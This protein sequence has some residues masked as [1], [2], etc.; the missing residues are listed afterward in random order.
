MADYSSRLTKRI[1]S[2]GDVLVD[3][4]DDCSFTAVGTMSFTDGSNETKTLSDLVGSGPAAPVAPSEHWAFSPGGY[5]NAISTVYKS[6]KW[7][8]DGGLSDAARLY[9]PDPTLTA[10]VT[11]MMFALDADGAG[12]TAVEF[13]IKRN[14]VTLETKAFSV[15]QEINQLLTF[16]NTHE[17]ESGDYLDLEIRRTNG[18]NNNDCSAFMRYYYSY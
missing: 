15:T 11:G 1:C 5:Q 17:F 4:G 16:D 6:F 14:G 8:A 9:F 10:Y 7:V 2:S 3:A 12:T 18:A 13:Q